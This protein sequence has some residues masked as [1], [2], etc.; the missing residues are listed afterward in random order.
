MDAD[1]GDVLAHPAFIGR[2]PD[3]VAKEAR[4]RANRTEL[5]RQRSLHGV[6]D[7]IGR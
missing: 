2:N 4:A 1:T 7:H 5:R 3:E 6:S